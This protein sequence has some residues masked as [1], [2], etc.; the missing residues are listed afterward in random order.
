MIAKDYFKRQATTLRKLVRITRNP[1][2]A[3]RLS[4]MAEDFDARCASEDSELGPEVHPSARPAD[5]KEGHD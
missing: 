3:D 5:R 4:L 1:G 2:I